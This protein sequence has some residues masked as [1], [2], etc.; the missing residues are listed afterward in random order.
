MSDVYVVHDTDD[1]LGGESTGP[2]VL[3]TDV[4]IADSVLSQMRGLMFRSSVPEE[5]ALVME[6]GSG[7]GLPLTSGP[8]RQFVHMLFVRMSLDVI[9]LND[10]EVVKVARMHPWRSVGVAR[11]DRIIEL[12]AGGAEGVSIGD[13]V[14]LADSDELTV[15]VPDKSQTGEDPVGQAP[16]G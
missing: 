6:V 1:T 7:G 15:T 5:F 4:E 9:W 13:T 11:A 2:R 12:P 16:S 10:D 3:A 14:R 8:P